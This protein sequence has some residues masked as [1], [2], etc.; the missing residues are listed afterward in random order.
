MQ[1]ITNYQKFLHTP[2][3][4]ISYRFSLVNGR[5]TLHINTTENASHIFSLE[6]LISDERNKSILEVPLLECK[7]P[8]NKNLILFTAI[9]PVLEK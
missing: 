6:V 5:N 8:E 9:C 2:K 7:F 1:T 3:V 4:K